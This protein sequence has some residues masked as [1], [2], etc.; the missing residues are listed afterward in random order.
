LT[1]SVLDK[2]A[3][4]VPPLVIQS[5]IVEVLDNFTE[6]TARKKQYEYYRKAL[7]H[8]PEYNSVPFSSVISLQ[9]GYDLPKDKMHGNKYPVVGSNGIIN[10]YQ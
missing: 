8:N 10:T 4:A 1:K 2:V 6:L 7:I 3:I 5:K 9:R